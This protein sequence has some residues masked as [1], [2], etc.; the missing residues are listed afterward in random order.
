ML[1]IPIQ[2]YFG[3]FGPPEELARV[4]IWNDATGTKEIGNY[5]YEISHKGELLGQGE[6]KN[7][8]R[9]EETS[10]RLLYLILKDYYEKV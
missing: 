4:I 10:V 2:L 7:F 3:G 5:R 9:L 8:P 6:I 1:K